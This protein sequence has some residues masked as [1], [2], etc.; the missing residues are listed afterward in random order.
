MKKAQSV[1]MYSVLMIILGTI[2]FTSVFLL[3][4]SIEKSGSEELTILNEDTLLAKIENKIL[5][6]KKISQYSQTNIETLMEIPSDIGGQEYSVLGYNDKIKVRVLSSTPLD[7]ERKIGSG[8][9][10][11]G[12][13]FP[14]TIHLIYNL[15]TNSV[16]IK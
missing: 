9:Q 1:V 14:P 4:T 7:R 16:T 15:S 11:S 6:M 13:S 8:I 10:C 2:I 12:L 3:S 5:D